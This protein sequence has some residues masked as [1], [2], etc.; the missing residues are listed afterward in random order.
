MN[1]L[2]FY[3]KKVEKEENKLNA[4]RRKDNN[5]DGKSMKLKTKTDNQ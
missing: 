5:K 2:N 1:N 3:L 4:S